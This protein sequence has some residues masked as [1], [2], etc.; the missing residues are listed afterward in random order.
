MLKISASPPSALR[1]IPNIPMDIWGL[2]IAIDGRI[3]CLA[4]SSVRT[5]ALIAV[6]FI[7]ES[8]STPVTTCGLRSSTL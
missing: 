7:R 4:P 2:W 8:E 1:L 3:S 5:T 6:V